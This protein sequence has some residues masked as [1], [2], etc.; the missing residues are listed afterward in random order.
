MTM[1]S[2]GAIAQ[3]K[4]NKDNI[5]DVLKAMTLEEKASLLV[6]KSRFVIMNGVPTG[7]TSKVEGAAGETRAIE[8]LG[9][10]GTVLSDGPAGVR[11][12]PTRKGDDN[13]YYAT[14][15]PVGTVLAST[16]DAE[17]VQRVTK[18]MGE[19][20]KDFGIDVLLAPGMN[21]QRNPLCGR[22]FEYFSEDPFL[23]GKM[24]AA[25]AKGI[26]ENGVGVSIKHFMGNNQETNRNE[27]DSRI[28]QRALREI[29]L[30]N[31]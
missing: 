1:A 27:V 22:N 26:Q 25:Y 7:T 6:G 21:I 9:I 28:S 11:I 24:A 20:A 10:P 17:L 30:K 15:F 29:Y 18:A 12:S 3:P 31:F 4:L 5:E 8:R 19:E 16:W 14:A 13:T 2:I 23:S